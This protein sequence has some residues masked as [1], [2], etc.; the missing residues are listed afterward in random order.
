VTDVA[1]YH[2]QNAPL[3]RVLP[4]LLEKTLQA[5]KRAVVMAGSAER[6]EDLNGLLWTY[7]P[8]SW[9]PH[10]SMRDG[11]AERQPVWLTAVDENPNEASFLFLTDG[12]TSA[13]I[14][15]FERC[16]DLF[17]GNDETAVAVARQRWLACKE[18]GFTLTYW[19]QSGDGR[20]E[21]KA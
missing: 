1:F 3:D 16:F 8:D 18:A 13:R 12:T 19:Q 4:R 7:E 17:D 14:A 10:G 21:R 5:G 11:T 20:W 6:V 2:L 15:Q 9:L